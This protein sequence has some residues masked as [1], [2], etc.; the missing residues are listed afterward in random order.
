MKFG[1]A[2]SDKI[3]R[4]FHYDETAANAQRIL[5]DVTR[6]AF[7]MS[8]LKGRAEDSVFFKHL[9]DPFCFSPLDELTHEMK[10]TFLPPN[11]DFRCRTK[12]LECKQE[13][14]S[15]QGYIHDLRVLA[16]NNRSLK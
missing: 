7:V 2:L 16:A 6:V 1:G 3:L 13:K 5:D 9:K 10:T 11:G 12:Y 8:H 14:R 15:L 4:W